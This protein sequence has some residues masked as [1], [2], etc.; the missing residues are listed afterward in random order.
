VLD[1]TVSDIQSR[2]PAD[3]IRLRLAEGH[4]LPNSLPGVIHTE[5]RGAYYHLKLDSGD[6]AGT[7][8]RTIAA[9]T[10]VEHFELLRP[11]LHNIFIRIAG[12]V[13]ESP[14]QASMAS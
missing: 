6:S 2:Y 4:S 5:I 8:L 13:A 11:S 12:P 9:S 10:M 14:K 1:G 3:E 7:L